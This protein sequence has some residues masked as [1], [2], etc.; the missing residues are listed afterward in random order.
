MYLLERHRIPEG[1]DLQRL[2]DY[3]TGVFKTIPSRKGIKKALKRGQILVDGRK[4]VSGLWVQEGMQVELYERSDA[5]PKMLQLSVP[6]LFEDDHLA[7][8]RK[9]AGL[10]VSGNRYRTLFNAL[11]FNLQTSVHPEALP[12]PLP[13]HR[14][15]G[16]TAGLVLVAKSHPCRR[17]L[18]KLLEERKVLKTYQ[19]IVIGDPPEEQCIDLPLEGKESRTRLRCI[20]EIQSL[21]YGKLAWLQVSPE[22]GR[23]HQIRK[24]LAQTGY[25][26]LGDR[27]Y[28]PEATR[29]KGK[30]LFLAAT[31][32]GLD[33]PITGTPVEV[34]I[35][36][37]QKYYSLWAR[38]QRYYQK[39]RNAN[40]V[41]GEEE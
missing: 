22:T 12:W 36:A 25:P 17:A 20:K 4:G 27:L 39:A 3:L 28:G 41:F 14:L 26:I 34:R 13:A 11:P 19:C 24:H 2:G 8:V 23:T 5:P 33:H 37:P 35:D 38:E 32:L 18:G 6:V 9:P 15:D 10:V 7:I 1:V 16:P 31:G 30:G 21:R 40:T 29:L